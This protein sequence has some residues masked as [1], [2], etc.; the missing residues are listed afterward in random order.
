MSTR[1]KPLRKDAQRNRDLLI[2]AARELYAARGL[3]VSLDEIARTAGVSSGTLYN[4]FPDRADLVEAV[5][6]DRAATVTRIAEHALAMDAPWEG[7]VHFLEGVCELQA[8]DRG[9]NDLLSGRVPQAPSSEALAHGY[10]LMK[11]V[12]DRARDSGALRPDF[13]LEDVAFLTWGTA[14][15]IEVTTTIRPNAWRRH[16]SLLLDALRP[17]AAH[18]LPEP[19]LTPDEL[20][21]LMRGQC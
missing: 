5:F 12:I 7:L 1:A 10:T 3:D 18:P 2:K 15:T 4:H 11:R 19:P 6:A 20:A 13:T 17:P 8:A 21:Q 9:Y 16:L 14:R